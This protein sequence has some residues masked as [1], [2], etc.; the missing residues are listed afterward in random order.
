MA[1][2]NTS[3]PSDHKNIW[4]GGIPPLPPQFEWDD[5]IIQKLIETAVSLERLR[6]I[7]QFANLPSP[8][9]D[10]L[11]ARKAVDAQRL[12]GQAYSLFDLYK[13]EFSLRQDRRLTSQHRIPF[14]HYIALKQHTILKI[15]TLDDLFHLHGWLTVGINAPKEAVFR[16]ASHVP[17]LPLLPLPPA[18]QIEGSLQNLVDYLKR[19]KKPHPLVKIA[20]SYYQLTA[21]QP[22]SFANTE[23]A[24]LLV[25]R[26]FI[27]F[28][29]FPLPLLNLAATFQAK[30]QQYQESLLACNQTGD[31]NAWLSFFLGCVRQSASDTTALITKRFDHLFALTKRLSDLF[32]AKTAPWLASFLLRVPAF[33]ASYMEQYMQFSTQH[34]QLVIDRLQSEGIVS[35]FPKETGYYIPSVIDFWDPEAS[36]KVAHK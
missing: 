12:T 18:N 7:V 20:L 17:H 2:P 8:H 3:T 13:T 22:F 11:L 29:Q 23:L 15:S 19:G 21:L 32:D 34:T 5:Q 30:E 16:T 33:S 36:G 26:L 9:F 27:R 4:K 1:Q 24:L 14:D 35:P 6:W 10:P 31:F 28:Q 25:D